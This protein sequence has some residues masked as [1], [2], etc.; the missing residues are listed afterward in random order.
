MLSTEYEY[1]DKEFIRSGDTELWTAFGSEKQYA[2]RTIRPVR[3]VFFSPITL[4]LLPGGC[5]RGLY[6]VL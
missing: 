3:D 4:Q 5:I 6:N 1:I 2:Y